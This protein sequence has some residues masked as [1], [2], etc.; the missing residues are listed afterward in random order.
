MDGEASG[1]ERSDDD[2][3]Y[4]DV[5]IVANDVEHYNYLSLVSVIKLFYFLSLLHFLPSTTVYMLCIHCFALVNSIMWT[6]FFF[7][8]TL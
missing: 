3:D 8:W 4:L 2:N 7:S 5:F 1:D 6:V